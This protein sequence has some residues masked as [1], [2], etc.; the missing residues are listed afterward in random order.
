MPTLQAEPRSWPL[1][2]PFT[3]SRGTRTEARTV[4]VTLRDDDGHAGRGEAVPYARHGETVEQTLAELAAAAPRLARMGSLHH[5]DIPRLLSGKAARTALDCAL[6][7]LRARR[8][9]RPA[10]QLAGLPRPVP[11]VTAFTISLARPRDM[12]RQAREN[13]HRPLLK[14]KLGGAP[15]E[16]VA[17]LRAVR[18]AAP[19]ARIIVDANEGWKERHLPAL[20][21]ACAGCGVELVEQPLPAGRDGALAG[22]DSPVP[23]CADE[24]VHE[25]ADLPALAP[26]YDAVNIKL[27]KSGGLS[28]ALELLHAAQDKGLDVM[29]GCMLA[30]SLAMAP[31]FLLA[32]CA[33]W[34]DLDGPLLLAEDSTPPLREENGRLTPP[35]PA[36]WG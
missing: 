34:V 32:A 14:L 36:L 1:K 10:W 26:A 22:I 23:L 2:R 28:A 6:W 13:A 27:D 12:A 3:I 31:A 16:D 35:Q 33:R 4:I 29:I 15:D 8:C 25:A 9:G 20:L 18:A 11:L 21:A 5:E 30:S 19:R 17:R 24:S 7:D